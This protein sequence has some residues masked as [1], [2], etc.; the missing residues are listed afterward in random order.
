MS[1]ATPLFLAPLRLEA[2]AAR[3]GA[4]GASVVQIGMGPVRATAARVRTASGEPPGRPLVLL[5]FGGGLTA[6]ERAGELVVAS[7]VGPIDA[8]ES[9]VFPEAESAAAHLAACGVAARLAPIVS[10]PTMLAGTHARDRAAATGARV[11]DME[12]L[13]C[14]PLARR[15]PFVVVRAVVDTRGR[16]LRSPATPLAALRAWRALVVAARAL[17]H[18]DPE[19]VF[20]YPL[21]EVGDS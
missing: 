14:A 4:P 3:R 1:S 18:W 17:A 6:E 13:W 21:L 5:G 15:H 12:T 11:V 16:E 20:A 8:E 19:S 2:L 9:F 10:S 7:S